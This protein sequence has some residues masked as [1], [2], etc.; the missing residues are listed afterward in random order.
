[1]L[2]KQKYFP[3]KR[4]KKNLN[5]KNGNSWNKRTQHTLGG[6][7]KEDITGFVSYDPENHEK[8]AFRDQKKLKN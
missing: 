3:Y 1:M 8:C 2:L 4:N 5:K 6:L 7:E